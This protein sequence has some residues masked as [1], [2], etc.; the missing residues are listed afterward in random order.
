MAKDPSG[1]ALLVHAENAD[2]IASMLSGRG[3]KFS[4][5]ESS[6]WREFQIDPLN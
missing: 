4:V 1:F 5:S 3:R 2:R 6:G